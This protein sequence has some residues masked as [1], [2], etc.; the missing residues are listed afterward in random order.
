MHILQNRIL[1]AAFFLILA[2]PFYVSHAEEFISVG[3]GNITGIY[4]PAGSNICRFLN[5]NRKD[6]GIRCSVAATSGSIHNLD[7]LAKG[8][9]DFVIV[10]SDLQF[11]NYRGEDIYEDNANP[12]LRSV[13]SLHDDAFT[14]VSRKD[15]QIR[16]F[17][18]LKNKKIYLGNEGS[19]SR[20][21]M[22]ILMKFK[23]WDASDIIDTVNFKSRNY[24]D[25]LCSGEIDA[26]VYSS[27]NP[28]GLIQE[29]ATSCDTFIVPVEGKEIDELIE[30]FS[31]YS[32]TEIPGG[33]Y[34]GNPYDIKTFGFKAT[35]VTKSSTDEKIVYNLV[36]SVFDNF[37]AFKKT[38]PVFRDLDMKKMIS[39]GNTAPLHEGAV[40]FYKE[41][42]LL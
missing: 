38:L 20:L 36:K 10:Q 18:D 8:S 42:G 34:A 37:D 31:Y 26:I 7:S 39:T 13:F 21:T 4:Y 40:R 5:K 41:K 32:K 1:K 35:L 9:L 17:S 22:Q 23:G 14:I 28:N 33:L 16:N 15:A 29:T 3:T 27:G 12:E 2:N 19:G 11:K 25:A 30:H 24:S 6:H